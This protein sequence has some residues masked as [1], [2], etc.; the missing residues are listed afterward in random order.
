MN[1]RRLIFC[2]YRTLHVAVLT[3]L[4][5]LAA[6]PL[7]WPQPVVAQQGTIKKLSLA[8]VEELVARHVP[9]S[10]MHTEIQRRGLAFSPTTAIVESLRATGAGPLTLSALVA[11]LPKTTR[12]GV[13]NP[14]G[15]E[16]A[17]SATLKVIER[18]LNAQTEIDRTRTQHL[19][20]SGTVIRDNARYH[21]SNLI[22]DPS[23][24]T[25]KETHTIESNTLRSQGGRDSAS[26]ST[27]RVEIT[28]S[29]K[30]VEQVSVEREGDS[31]NLINAKNGHPE[32]T[33][34]VAPPVY[35]VFLAS[36]TA[37]FSHHAS[38]TTGDHQAAQ[39]NNDSVKVTAFLFFDEEMANR[40]GEAVKRAAKLCGGNSSVSPTP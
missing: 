24:C 19:K 29:L 27:A 12:S 18:T 23:T 35:F 15:T 20:S 10:T 2:L 39:V 9:D 14:A 30:D 7:L 1:T 5:G 37:A 38:S 13:S 31:Y 40:A 25:I 26:S 36:S 33:L 11:L 34:T 4:V 17:L 22:V 28:L 8:Q 32:D 6:S 16:S 21:L 3:F